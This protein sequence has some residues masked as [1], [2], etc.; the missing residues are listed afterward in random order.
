MFR[1]IARL[2]ADGTI[3]LYI[4]HRLEEVMQIADRLVVLKDGETVDHFDGSDCSKDRLIHSM[5]G[6]SFE[7]MFPPRGQAEP[8]EMLK[9][10][11][12]VAPG[13]HG[14]SFTA[15]KGEIVGIG[16]LVGSGRSEVLRGIFG[17][18]PAS[19]AQCASPGRSCRERHPAR[20]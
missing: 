17:A 16:G 15:N 6:R 7:A 19:R 4:S 18:A 10:T 12:L 3:I 9:V 2:R 8:T 11:D 20:R 14:V 1:Q 5:V 13:V